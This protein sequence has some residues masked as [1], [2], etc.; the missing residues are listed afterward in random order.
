MKMAE[1]DLVLPISKWAW[2]SIVGLAL[3]LFSCSSKKCEGISPTGA[4]TWRIEFAGSVYD[5]RDSLPIDGALVRINETWQGRAD[6]G[7]YQIE[8]ESCEEDPSSSLN[9]II[10]I[11][12][13]VPA[14]LPYADSF[15]TS[16]IPREIAG[17]E[18]SSGGTRWLLPP[19]YVEKRIP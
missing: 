15:P 14:Y 8:D 17:N 10:G 6:S 1:V 9:G 16:G 13:T 7:F 18:L 3:G 2:F 5:S 19:I 12:I 11:K 4:W